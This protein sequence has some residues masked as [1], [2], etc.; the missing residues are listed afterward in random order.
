[1]ERFR[2]VHAFVRISRPLAALLA[3]Y[4]LYAAIRYGVDFL[5]FMDVLITFQ[6]KAFLFLVA[7]DL[8][9]CFLSVE[10]NTRRQAAGRPD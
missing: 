2:F 3:I 1:M 10:E 9:D 6:V 7:G 8:L 5:N 4:G